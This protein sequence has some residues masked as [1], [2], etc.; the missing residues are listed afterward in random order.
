MGGERHQRGLESVLIRFPA[1]EL[2]GTL[3]RPW[4]RGRLI[5]FSDD[6]FLKGKH[7]LMLGRG[8]V[9]V[10]VTRPK[11]RQ[12]KGKH[13]WCW[14]RVR[15]VKNQTCQRM[16]LLNN[17]NVGSRSIKSPHMKRVQFP[18]LAWDSLEDDYRWS[19]SETFPLSA[20]AKWTA[21][22]NTW[23]HS[24]TDLLG[25]VFPQAWLLCAECFPGKATYEPS[26]P[27]CQTKT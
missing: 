2:L 6:F 1:A 13:F 17:D 27:K 20:P 22:G 25:I 8:V 12:V 4:I 14:E 3:E 5:L 18:K 11:R 24:S 26:R 19:V 23:K 21:S 9:C 15:G 7:H 10:K 16:L